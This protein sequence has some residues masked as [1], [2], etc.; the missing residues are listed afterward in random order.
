MKLITLAPGHFH[1]ALVQKVARPGV[2]DRATVYAPLG[3]DLIAHLG[4]IAAFNQ[5][6]DAPTNWR[7]DVRAGADYYERFLAE[8]PGD[9]L[10]LSGRNRGKIDVMLDAVRHGLDVLADKPWVIRPEDVPKI[11]ELFREADRTGRVVCD[12]MTERFEATTALQRELMRDPE[13][14]GEL[15]PGARDRPA[16]V[17]RSLHQLSKSVAGMPLRR[18]AWFFDVAEQGEG[19]ADVGTHLVDLAMWLLFPD[20]AIDY[21]RD[22]T[23]IEGWRWPT[24]LHREAFRAVTGLDDFPDFLA[25]AIVTREIAGDQLHYYCNNQVLYSLRGAYVELTAAWEYESPGG[26]THH[27]EARGSRSAVTVWQGPGPDDRPELLVTPNQ[28]ADRPAVR[29]ALEH[30]LRDLATTFPGV[31]VEERDDG[32][33]VRVPDALRVGHE[34]HFAQV[35]DEFLAYCGRRREYPAWERPNLLAKYFTTTRGVALANRG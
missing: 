26:D 7:L 14:F 34:A 16:L 11:E 5:R 4:R 23:V 21:R 17:I 12:I 32:L 15:P 29:G 8:R 1:A 10:I 2:D 31:S 20:Q 33:W 18:P 25:H 19:L 9:V 24:I 22:V 3:D 28:P 35:F 27:A 13:V 30:R 6:A